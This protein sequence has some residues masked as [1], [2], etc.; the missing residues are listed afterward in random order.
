[1]DCSLPGSSIC[2]IFQARILDWVAISFFLTQRLNPDLPHCRQTLYRL[3]LQGSFIVMLACNWQLQLLLLGECKQ[4]PTLK[5]QG[6]SLITKVDFL[7]IQM[8]SKRRIPRPRNTMCSITTLLCQK[9]TL[10]RQLF[11]HFLLLPAVISFVT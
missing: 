8:L 10:I 6:R 4:F 2:G 3:S 9:V 11:G 5:I 1:M 7:K